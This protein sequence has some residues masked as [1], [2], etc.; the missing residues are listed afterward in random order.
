MFQNEHMNR[1]VC[2]LA[3][4]V[5]Q[6]TT[7][8]GYHLYGD[9]TWREHTSIVKPPAVAGLEGPFG[10]E[11]KVFS[12][13]SHLRADQQPLLNI[14]RQNRWTYSRGNWSKPTFGGVCGPEPLLFKMVSVK[15]HI[16]GHHNIPPDPESSFLDALDARDCSARA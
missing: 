14:G 15:L 16:V 10:L 11:L 3:L 13:P 12:Y 1:L 4:V 7:T 8:N 2:C 9:R 5:S 6:K